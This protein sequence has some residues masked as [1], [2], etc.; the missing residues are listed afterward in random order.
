MLRPVS[1]IQ[2]I[3]F[4][5]VTNIFDEQL[6]RHLRHALNRADAAVARKQTVY[7]AVQIQFCGKI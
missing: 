6:Q 4:N 7:N 2:V 1:P 5:L 3:T